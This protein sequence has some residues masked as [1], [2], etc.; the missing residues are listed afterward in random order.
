MIVFWRNKPDRLR[1]GNNEYD[2]GQCEYISLSLIIHSL[3][4]SNQKRLNYSICR[5]VLTKGGIFNSS[6]AKSETPLSS[7]TNGS[8]QLWCGN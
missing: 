7:N 1:L 3:G 5:N 6:Y 4:H 2:L 8:H